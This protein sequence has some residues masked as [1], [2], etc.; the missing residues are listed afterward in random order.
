MKILK[1]MTAAALLSAFAL[2]AM[3][4]LIDV[5]PRPATAMFATEIRRDKN[6]HNEGQ[7]GNDIYLREGGESSEGRSA[8]IRWGASGTSYDWMLSY[9]GNI[10]SLTV[11]SITRTLNVATDGLWSMVALTVRS[12][13]LARFESARVNVTIDR[14]N[15]TVNGGISEFTASLGDDHQVFLGLEDGGSIES[16][17]GTLTFTFAAADDARGS[18]GTLFAFLTEGYATDDETL[19]A[20][21]T[22]APASLLLF[23]PFA[24]AWAARRRVPAKSPSG[25]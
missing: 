9:D 13:D 12:E 6:L 5:S 1:M 17:S 14:V 7:V 21:A 24:V 10:A 23:V 25:R 22:P 4:G 3:A 18:P 19:A 11:D 2:P 15:G 20:T 16:L 8:N